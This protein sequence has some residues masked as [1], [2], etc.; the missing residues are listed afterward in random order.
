MPLHPQCQAIVDAAKAAGV[1]FEADD[2]A[3]MRT[4]YRAS[5]ELYR[6]ATPALE[7]V[8]NLMFPGPESNVPI[9]LYRPRSGATTALP[10]LVFYHGGG[11]VVGDLDTHDHMC[12]YLA[13]HADVL[14][15]SVDYRLAPEHKFPAAFDDACAAARWVTSKAGELGI[16]RARIAV[17]GDSAGGNL[18]AAVALALR[19][20]GDVPLSL[21]LLIYPALD[22]TADNDSLRDNAT[23]Y[24]LTRKAM[25]QFTDWYLPKRITRTDPHASPQLAADHSGL[26]AALIQTAEFD[27]LRD[28]AIAYVATLRRAGVVVDHRHYEG[29]IHGFARMGGKVDHALLALDDAVKALRNAF[30]Q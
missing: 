13:G 20:E 22:F 7:S 17:G 5:T 23:G 1:P 9:R 3:T 29:M 27:P 12:R 24:M 10:A 30:G 21:Q 2:Y 11:W 28:E 18:A 6:H 19:D 25:E 8:A 16:D 14:V 15:A 26:P 4:F